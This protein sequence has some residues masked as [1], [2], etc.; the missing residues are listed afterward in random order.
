MKQIFSTKRELYEDIVNNE[1][2]GIY[3]IRVFNPEKWWKNAWSSSTNPPYRME[4]ASNRFC[5]ILGITREEFEI[6]PEVIA[7]LIHPEDKQDFATKNEEANA[8]TTPFKWEGRL[9]KKD[10]ISW[11]HLESIP[12]SIDDGEILWTGIL[13]DITDQKQTE[14]ALK[15]SEIKYRELVDNSPEAIAIYNASGIVFINHECLHLMRASMAD[16]LIGK[17]VIDFVHPDYRSFVSDRMNNTLNEGKT[18]PLTDEKFIRLDGETIDVEVKSMPILFQNKAAVQLIVRDITD[19]KNAENEV[20]KNR[21]DFKDLFDYAPVG[22]HEIDA[23][24]R[25]VRMNQTELTMLGYTPDEV[26]GQ[27]I[28]KFNVDENYASTATKEKILGLHISSKTYERNFKRKDGSSITVLEKDRVLYSSDGSVTGIRTSVNDISERKEAELKL[29]LS[30]EKF[31][32]AFLTSPDSVN[33]NRLEDGL[34]V[35][36]NNGFTRIM[37]YNEED[38]MGKTSAD[39]NVW[40]NIKDRNN[41]VKELKEKGIV[42][43][44]I[45]QFRTKRGRLVYGM[46]SA[47]VIDLDGISHILSITRDIT[48]IKNTEFAL[49]QSEELYSN[50]V[51]RIPDGVY[52]STEQGKF[53][54]VNPA[55]VKMLGYDDKE[56]LMNINIKSQ[57][58]FDIS[59]RES[60]ILNNQNEVMSVFP[61]KK[62]DGSKIWIEDHGWYNMDINGNIVTHEGV[63]R[64]ITER[65]LAQ[66]ELLESKAVLNDLLYASAGFIDSNT[67]G[68]DYKKMTDTILK[69]T[70]AKYATLNILDDNGGYFTT[71]AVSG[72]TNLQQKVKDTLG[73]EL[74]YKKWKTDLNTVE[75]IKLNPITH[76]NTLTD[77]A[78]NLLSKTIIRLIEKTFNIDKPVT[79]RINKNN[80]FI[81]AFTFIFSKGNILKNQEI[82]ELF[83]YQAGLYIDRENSAKALQESEGKY[84]YLF[85]NNPQPMYIHDVDTLEFLEIN[86]AAI[87]HYGYSKEEF[88]SMTLKDIRPQ[89]DIT[90]LLVDVKD[91]RESFKSSGV[92]RHLKKNGEIIFVE[93]TAVSVNLDGKKARHVMILDVTER[94]I[95]ED[96]LKESEDKYRTMIENSND[97]IWTLD[98]NGHFTFANKRAIKATELNIDDWIGKSFVPLIMSEDLPMVTDVF[99]RTMNGAACNYELRFKKKDDTIL[100]IFVNTSPIYHSGKIEGVVSFGRDITESKK[101]MQQLSESEEKFRSIAEQ[102]GD[103]IS[104]TD[105]A[106]IIKYVSRASNAIF[107]YE[108]E[109]MNEHNFMEFLDEESK[110]KALNAFR[111]SM[112]SGVNVSNL[113][114]SMKKKDGTLFYGELNGSRFMN[115]QNNGTLVVI[116]DISERKKAQK[117]LEE[118]MNDLIRFNRLT[119]D[120]ELTMIELKKEINELLAKTGQGEKY[121]IVT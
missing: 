10:K 63:L 100:T 49:Q 26:I 20:K 103:L 66:D 46:M 23:E 117:E 78:G 44:L 88:L 62:K 116:R 97:L 60:N 27:F 51:L 83:A 120:R 34:Y 47:S 50:L 12:R 85:F 75:Q 101:A 24:G 15:E 113:E 22:Y 48:E 40:E 38:V 37:G 98:L 2:A 55:M 94:K 61:L 29:Q 16:E 18:L 104:I 57:L 65:K 90:A 80:K 76:F 73:F 102:T 114:L 70:G 5:E 118:K 41:L 96:A 7:D 112:E 9:M 119:V 84:R 42:E 107:Q 115:S 77:L 32:T 71:L 110:V 95:A 59:D 91:S 28:W 43:N 13:Y 31:K 53:I 106:G 30:E 74:L 11:I 92:W 72:L 105:E 45:T 1:P 69:I 36:I 52:K 8:G 64:D 68:I 79:V 67:E 19:R 87:D 39:I 17:H 14:T 35:S 54:D 25:I 6:N 86:Q 3:R 109:E 81:G 93:I 99:N 111:K 4:L 89:E 82:V 56:E 108:Q 121:R 33:I 21:E 58:Y